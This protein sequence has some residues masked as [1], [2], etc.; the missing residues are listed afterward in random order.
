M[1][2][3][4]PGTDGTCKSATAEGQ[5]MEIISFLTIKQADAT[6]NPNEV[7]NVFGSHDQNALV[8]AGTFALATTQTIG[9]DGSLTLA[10]VPYLINTGFTPGTGGT[11]KSTTPEA[12][13]LEV[14]MYLQALEQTEGANP[15]NRNF[16]TG[17]YNSDTGLYQ[18]SFSVP[19]TVALDSVT[20]AIEYTAAPYLSL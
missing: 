10:A 8:F 3:V 4:T 20:G 18:G 9:G 6:A 13:A 17:S 11:F 16:I 12:Y 7:T 14:L 5:L 15:A 19:C 1:A 2:V